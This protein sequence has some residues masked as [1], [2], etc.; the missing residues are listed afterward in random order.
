MLKW[1]SCASLGVALLRIRVFRATYPVVLV[2][3]IGT[4]MQTVGAQ[5]L[6]SNEANAAIRGSFC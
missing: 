4:W 2:S 5:W 1:I 6:L 3:N